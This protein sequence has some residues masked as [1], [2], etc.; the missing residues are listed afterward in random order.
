MMSL[1]GYVVL[2]I[3]VSF[4][5]S[6][7]EATLLSITPGYI[8]RLVSERPA[9]GERLRNLKVDVDRPLAAILSLNTI[10]NT[11]GAAGV[12]VEAQAVFGGHAM[13]IA[14]AVLT[15]LI[16]VF[17]EIIPKTVGA[18]YW[19]T[20]APL[21][22]RVLP[23]MILVTSPLVWLSQQITRILR[24]GKKASPGVSKEEIAALAKLGAEQGLFHTNES[25]ILSNLFRFGLLLARDIM[26]PRTVMFALSAKKT[27]ADVVPRGSFPGREK[28]DTVQ[29]TTTIF[30]RIIVYG[31]NHD[32]V[33]GYVLKSELYLAAA[34][35]E[36]ALPV[37]DLVREILTVPETLSVTSLFERLLDEREHIALVIDE[38]GGV[39]G[40]VTM[41]DVLETLLGLEIVD[42]A[43]TAEDLREIARRRWRERRSKLG[44][45]PPPAMASVAPASDSA[46]G[47]VESTPII[48][49]NPPLP[50]T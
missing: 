40:V 33:L 46:A 36:L 39:D 3:T 30:S 49:S 34:R 2:A 7:L 44:T 4:A 8:A 29:T 1:I 18:T 28:D 47:S 10:A 14:S 13:A 38:Y 37:G 20:L 42:E 31:E 6:V 24:R 15:F 48:P 41:E 35:G 12:G 9:V 50:D 22:A 5:C 23:A 11:V 26:T 45:L 21:A 32:D 16:L 25:R 27:V 19:R 17:A 43:D